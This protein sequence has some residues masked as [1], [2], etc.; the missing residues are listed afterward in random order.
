M[1]RGDRSIRI[2]V[3]PPTVEAH[4]GIFQYAQSML[5]VLDDLQH[6]RSEEFV[7]L[8]NGL[9]RGLP[10]L[11]GTELSILPFVPQDLSGRLFERLARIA[12]SPLG[13][14][15]RE[16]LLRALATLS[17]RRRGADAGRVRRAAVY[18]WLRSNGIDFIVYPSPT[19]LSFEV[20]I[21]YAMAVHDLQHRLHPEF[22]EVTANGEYEAREYL[23]R[24]GIG[25]ATIV[26]VDSDVGKEDVL[27]HYG[28]LIDPDRICVLPFLP[29]ESCR[30]PPSPADRRRVASKYGLPE[31]FLFYP[32]QLWPHKNHAIL[33]RALGLLRKAEGLDVPLVLVGSTLGKVRSDTWRHVCTLARALGL[34]G[35][36]KHLGYVPDEDMAP[37]YANATA[38]T[39]PTWFGPTNI[40]V[41]EAWAQACPVLTSDIR[42]VREQAG[43]A[44]VLADPASAEDLAEGIR[45]LWVDGDLR[46]EL[47]ERGKRRLDSYT[48]QDYAAALSRILDQ[49][50][51][52][53]VTP[54]M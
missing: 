22:P 50:T 53:V 40:P 6:E 47:I 45:R 18:S 48:R 4:G 26:I 28:E 14:R 31:R 17:R 42:G 12:R 27:E 36:I 9:D 10:L 8:G 13:V 1:S 5:S 51:S 52:R 46:T 30:R 32:A 11:S 33:V 38:L 25:G 21:P 49:A 20:G 3:A 54:A 2:G 19:P 24:G 7:V 34:E 43:D 41:L 29:S 39:M 37:L 15:Y 16:P 23:Y 44:A 35:S